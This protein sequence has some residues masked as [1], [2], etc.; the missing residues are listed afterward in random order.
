MVFKSIFQERKKQIVPFQQFLF[1]SIMNIMIF[2]P[3]RLWI[4][5]LLS[6]FTA[7]IF[8]THSSYATE[9]AVR[10]TEIMYNAEGRD[11]NKEFVEVINAGSEVIDMTTVQFFERK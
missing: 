11:D 1:C 6:I 2:I 4:L 3:Y 10:I 8:F 5:C 9:P 7:G